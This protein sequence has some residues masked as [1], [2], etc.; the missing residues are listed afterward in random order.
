MDD[1]HN[2][3]NAD[4]FP[5]LSPFFLNIKTI[6]YSLQCRRVNLHNF[7]PQRFWSLERCHGC[8]HQKTIKNKPFATLLQSSQ[9]MLNVKKVDRYMIFTNSLTFYSFDIFDK[10]TQG[11]DAGYVIMFM[12]S[13]KVQTNYLRHHHSVTSPKYHHDHSQRKSHSSYWQWVNLFSD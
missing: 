9:C 7:V 11:G 6:N 3:V 5:F 2:K 13:W 8:H 12:C 1:A 10:N 4:F